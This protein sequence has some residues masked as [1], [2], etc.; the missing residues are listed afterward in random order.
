MSL[1]V[2]CVDCLGTIV[3]KACA[4]DPILFRCGLLEAPREFDLRQDWCDDDAVCVVCRRVTNGTP[5]F[6]EETAL[7]EMARCLV[8]EQCSYTEAVQFVHDVAWSITR[9]KP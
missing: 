6:V 7:D 4:V 1:H 5:H 8:H 3:A 9:Y 2:V